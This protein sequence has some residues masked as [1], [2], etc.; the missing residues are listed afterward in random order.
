MGLFRLYWIPRGRGP[1]DGAYV[2]YPSA[3][4]LDIVALESHRAGAW[5]CGE[6]LGT[7]EAGVRHELLA[8]R[9]L[10]YRLLWF[11]NQP[12]ATYPEQAMAAVT[13]HDLPTIA[14]VWNGA[15]LDAQRAAGVEPSVEGIA[16]I[17]RR[18]LE[19]TGLRPGAAVD[20]V[21]AAVY[22]ALAEAPSMV[23][24]ATLDDALGV[25]E[26]PNMPGTVDSWPNWR[27]ALPE[28]LE[29]VVTHPGPARVA[30]ALGRRR[31]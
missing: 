30:A 25:A 21:V 24:S 3:D 18:I 26:R 1:E 14:G 27:L 23:L 28:P 10:S 4:L 13:T 6:D 17:V 9:I 5:I 11:E 7:V 12:P 8:R 22:R 15:D 19:L 16:A 29:R 31:H 2:R 20:D